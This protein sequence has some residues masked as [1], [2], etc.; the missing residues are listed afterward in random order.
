VTG[1]TWRPQA[2]GTRLTAGRLAGVD[3]LAGGVGD[4][5]IQEAL[6][7]FTQAKQVAAKPAQ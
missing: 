5:K 1:V 7:L 4:K 3:V 6:D 2:A